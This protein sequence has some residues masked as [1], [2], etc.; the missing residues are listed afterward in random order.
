LRLVE[1]R[2]GL[3]LELLRVACR[4]TCLVWSCGAVL[5]RWALRLGPAL[6]PITSCPVGAVKLAIPIAV[7]DR[8]VD[9]ASVLRAVAQAVVQVYL[10]VF[11]ATDLHAVIKSLNRLRGVQVMIAT[12]ANQV[13]SDDFLRICH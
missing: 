1:L 5:W 4:G 9:Q 13:I 10:I 2:V 7:V 11:I 6:N 12:P 3:L 8:L